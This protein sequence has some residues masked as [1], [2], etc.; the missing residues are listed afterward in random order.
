MP[1]W[2]PWNG[3]VHYISAVVLFGMFAVFC[4]WLFRLGTTDPAPADKRRRNHTYV[5]CGIVILISMAWAGIAHWKN[6]PIFIP[7]SVALTAFAVSWLIKGRA[8]TSIAN[9]VRKTFSK[10]PSV[11]P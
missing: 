3:V 2:T 9:V 7:E 8:P 11:K 6:Y 4:L 10:A 1:W 5:A